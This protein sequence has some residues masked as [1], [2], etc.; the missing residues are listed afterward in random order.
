MNTALF[1]DSE[2]TGMVLWKEPSEHP[3]QPHIVQLAACLVDL[4]ARN[5]IAS[6][7][8]IV[9]PD[10]W[11]ISDEVT[12][13]HGITTEHALDVGISEPVALEMFLQLWS[14]RMRIGHNQSFDARIIR[15][16]QMRHGF[17]LESQEVWKAGPSE[18]TCYMAR[19]YTKLEKNKLPK[20]GEA[21]QHFSGQP[22][23]GAHSAMTD[24][25]GCMAVY[26]A[27]QDCLA[28]A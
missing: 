5:T 11:T 17:S 25:L 20:L 12:A 28:A 15:I 26:F 13:I 16:A 6:M 7:D 9:K 3:D 27:I 21:Y 10:G 1:Y 19:P 2:T 14:E 22:L 18:C 8:V 24:V 23:V 4:D